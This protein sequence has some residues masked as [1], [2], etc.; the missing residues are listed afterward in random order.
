MVNKHGFTRARALWKVKHPTAEEPPGIP[1]EPHPPAPRSKRTAPDTTS[2][3]N[4]IVKKR[5]EEFACNLCAASFKGQVGLT[6]HLRYFHPQ[7]YQHAERKR[8]RGMEERA[9]TFP[10]HCD[11][12]EFGA[13]SKT[14][15]L[16]HI[17]HKHRSPQDPPR[18]VT[19]RPTLFCPICRRIMGNAGGLASHM[20][21]KRSDGVNN[22]TQGPNKDTLRPSREKKGGGGTHRPAR[23]CQK[24]EKDEAELPHRKNRTRRET[25]S[26]TEVLTNR[27]GRDPCRPSGGRK[28]NAWCD[29]R[30]LPAWVQ[31]RRT[32]GDF[33]RAKGF[34]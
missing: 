23:H 31:W 24:Q 20:K 34:Q 13:L 32:A 16:S 19:P 5:R 3:P 14:G 17:R 28:H 4:P 26:T 33:M 12:W 6:R 27:E 10:F 2:D 1:P 30:G 21:Y 25:S 15:L 18:A 9:K 11:H 29:W 7:Q 22:R 8:A